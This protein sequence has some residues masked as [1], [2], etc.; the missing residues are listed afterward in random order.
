MP[1]S[2]TVS[3]E[4]GDKLDLNQDPIKILRPVPNFR[5]VHGP[6]QGGLRPTWSASKVSG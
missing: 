5:G 1:L 3:V 2:M 4:R 6:D